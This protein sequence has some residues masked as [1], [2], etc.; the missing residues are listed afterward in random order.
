MPHLS[1]LLFQLLPR[2]CGGS[3]LINLRDARVLAGAR[4]LCD[5]RRMV[6]AAGL[7]ILK[8]NQG[9]NRRRV[10]RRRDEESIG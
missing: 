9:E 3:V 2:R 10:G 7:Y 8:S 6:L 1:E 5:D 4:E